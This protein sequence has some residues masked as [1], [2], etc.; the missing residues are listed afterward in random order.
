MLICLLLILTIFSGLIGIAINSS[1]TLPA[2]PE[3]EQPAP[4]RWYSGCVRAS[5]TLLLVQVIIVILAVVTKF[6][7][8][9]WPLL[10]RTGLLLVYLP[11]FFA[12]V[13]GL[14]APRKYSDGKIQTRFSLLLRR[15]IYCGIQCAILF[16]SYSFLFFSQAS[17]EYT[18]QADTRDQANFRTYGAGLLTD[19]LVPDG[20]RPSLSPPKATQGAPER[21]PPSHLSPSRQSLRPEL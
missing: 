18:I 13:W 17:H 3:G 14:I 5:K 7:E 8:P 15:T 4:P 1:V 2:V 20:A 12:F 21:V 16:V 6:W 11:V 19:Q 9:N 10:F